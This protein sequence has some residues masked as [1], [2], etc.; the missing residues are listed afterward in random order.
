MPPARRSAVTG[1]TGNHFSYTLPALT[2]AHFILE[3]A[4]TGAPAI[5]T[6]PAN[7]AVAAGA[8]ATFSV[9]AT[10]APAPTYQWQ[11]NGAAI[12]GATG[13]SYTIAAVSVTDAASYT[14][15]VTN[16]AGSVTSSAALLNLII[17]PSHAVITITV[18]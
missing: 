3:T 5:T 8:S 4:A 12:A 2:A 13:S 10:G 11:K 18:Q 15:I 6:E 1:I 9:I 14:V 17:A 16:S 7:V